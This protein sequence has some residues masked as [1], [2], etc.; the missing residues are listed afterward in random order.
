MNGAGMAGLATVLAVAIGG[1]AGSVSRYAV[2][3]AMARASAGF[4]VGTLLVNVAGS[5]LIGVLLR[6]TAD[7]TVSRA[8]LTVGFCGGFTTF[9]AFSVE[10][11]ALLQQ[12]RTSRALLYVLVSIVLSVLAT[13]AGLALGG[14]FGARG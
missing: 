14:R 10:T 1:A 4:P 6:A 8:A 2:S 7:G 13:F 3:L 11:V 9:S 5:L 12:G